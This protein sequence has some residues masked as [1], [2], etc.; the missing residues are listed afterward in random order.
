MTTS[1]AD[2]HDTTVPDFRATTHTGE[3]LQLSDLLARGPVVLFFYPK[4]HTPGCTAEACH[5]RDLGA[6]FTALGA[7]RVGVSRD[8]MPTQASFAERNNLDYPLVADEDGAIARLFG[9]KRPGPLWSRRQTF[10]IGIDGRLIGRIRSETDMRKH[11][12]EALALLHRPPAE[13][14]E[15]KREEAMTGPYGSH[16]LVTGNS[17]G[18]GPVIARVFA[19]RAVDIT[20]VAPVRSFGPNDRVREATDVCDPQVA[21]TK[22]R[23]PGFALLRHEGVGAEASPGAECWDR[24]GSRTPIGPEKVAQPAGSGAAPHHPFEYGMADG[25]VGSAF[26]C[27]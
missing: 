8:P 24:A 18:V 13:P 12:D 20:L 2:P 26:P 25:T 1:A 27:W 7:Q 15:V 17:R 16:A 4:A 10:V 9:A 5:F 23:P 21:S 3:T 19:A 22:P 11:A 14:A 6:E